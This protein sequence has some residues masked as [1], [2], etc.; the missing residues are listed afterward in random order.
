MDLCRYESLL[1]C[2]LT[3]M[4][5]CRYG[6]LPLWMSTAMDINWYGCQLVWMSIDMVLY[7]FM[8]MFARDN[9]TSEVI[10]YRSDPLMARV[11]AWIQTSGSNTPPNLQFI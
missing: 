9:E 10:R 3:A 1:L 11:I 2:S 5:L 8:Q 6:A 4:E 7:T